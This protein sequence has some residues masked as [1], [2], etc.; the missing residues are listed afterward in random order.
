MT[1]SLYDLSV[2]TYEQILGSVSNVLDKGKAHA[3]MS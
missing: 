1:I 2:G 3:E